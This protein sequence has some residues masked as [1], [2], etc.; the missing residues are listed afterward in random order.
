MASWATARSHPYSSGTSARF[1]EAPEYP[2]VSSSR[3]L[4]H[5]NSRGI[6]LDPADELDWSGRGQHVEYDATEEEDIPLQREKHLG[7]SATAIVESVICRRIRLARKTIRCNRRLRKTEAIAEVEHLQRVQHKHVVRVV[8][9]YTFKNDLCIL[10]YPAAEWNLEEYMEDTLALARQYRERSGTNPSLELVCRRVAL[11]RFFGCLSYAM[12]FLSSKAIKHMD[13]KPKNLLVHPMA[14]MGAYKIYIADFGIARSYQSA[15]E[16]ETDSPTPFTRKYAAPEV[17]LQETRGFKAD[18]F[19]LGCIYVEMVA[20][21]ATIVKEEDQREALRLACRTKEGDTS[22]QANI[23]AV[24]DWYLHAKLHLSSLPFS[25]RVEFLDILPNMLLPEPKDRPTAK[26]V[27]Q[28]LVD[29]YGVHASC[30]RCDSGPEPFEAATTETAGS[31]KA[32][33]P[34]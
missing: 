16:S 1:T 7:H 20:T 18:I 25:L 22:Y 3:W 28:S 26:D 30:W 11:L 5:L 13:L 33:L 32:L 10:L 19:S 31:F 17:V 21:V 14:E 23:N 29:G 12:D 9:T 6:I 15:A 34:T 27:C 8:G 4:S 24:I 2:Q